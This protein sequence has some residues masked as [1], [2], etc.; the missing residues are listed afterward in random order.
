MSQSV[1][2]VLFCS[3]GRRA[4]L[5][6]RF[7]AAAERLDVGLEILACD[8]IPEQS[9]ACLLADKSFRVPRCND[10]G[11]P[12][13]VLSIVREHGVDLVVP[14]IDPELL[15]LS[16]AAEDF[17]ALGAR[18]HVSPESV[19]EVVRDK[20]R[21]SEVL[22]AAG[23]PVP[24]SADHAALLANPEA[25]GWPV[26]A[27]PGGGSSSRGLQVFQ[28][29]EEVP[30][31][32][33]EPMVFQKLLQGDE[34]TVNMF[35]DASGA[36]RTVV[37]HMRVQVR[38]GEVEKGRTVRRDDLH[39]IAEGI[40]RALPELR[41]VACFQVLDDPALGPRVIEINARFGGGYPLADE[42]GATFAQWL[43]EEVSGRICGAHD[44][45]RPGVW[46][47]RYDSAVYQG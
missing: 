9:A 25:L 27:K 26:F 33:P 44:D 2:R 10:A 32:F 29:I 15:P 22:A 17:A 13:S 5:V 18:L 20:L 37:P 30:E 36:L 38:A 4:G 7:R 16:R 11:Y 23:V 31:R 46:M 47:V 35:V 28:R 19:I 1:L 41:G 34:Y 21:T 14:T 40:V 24:D 12:D 45:W 3:A 6:E 43:L 39:Q 42:A 8:M